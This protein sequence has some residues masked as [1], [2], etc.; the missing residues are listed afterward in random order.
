MGG[1]AIIMEFCVHKTRGIS[2][3][4][5]KLLASQGGF[6]FMELRLN[7]MLI[8]LKLGATKSG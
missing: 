4:A 8:L 1:L 2:R 7:K 3:L 6:C 5:K